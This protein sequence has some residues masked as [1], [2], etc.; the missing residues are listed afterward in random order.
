VNGARAARADRRK[1]SGARGLWR[2]LSVA[3]VV[4]VLSSF[5]GN[6]AAAQSSQRPAIKVAPAIATEAGTQVPL[7]IAITPPGAA[8]PRSFV[9]VKGLPP[10]AALSD[11]HAIAPGAWAVAL[12]ALPNLQITVPVGAIGRSEIVITLVALDGAVLAEAKS[13]LDVSVARQA[14]R[15]PSPRE[16]GLPPGASMLRAVVPL[17]SAV[18]PTR[19]A[20]RN[21][22]TP[23][24]QERALR[25][26]KKGEEQLAEGNVAGAR[27]LYERAAEAGLALGAMS[28][29]ATFDADELAKLQVRGIQADAKEAR[30]WYER[31]RQLG[32]AEAEQR[33]RRLGAR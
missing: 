18:E 33:L 14:E 23:P 32:A 13:A 2:P 11:G 4:A 17:P 24:E 8:P 27:L 5:M 21:L 22:P 20:P 15:P 7:S 10:M 6:P 19:P 26:L 12:T 25:M 9:R 31:A 16:P 28:L 30:R 1:K 3:A 29:A